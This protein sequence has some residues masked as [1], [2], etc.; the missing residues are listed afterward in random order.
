MTRAVQKGNR[1]SPHPPFGEPNLL[2]PA[3]VMFV[4][5]ASLILA[6]DYLA[7]ETASEASTGP[8]AWILL[9]SCTASTVAALYMYCRRTRLIQEKAQIGRQ[10]S[11]AFLNAIPD[12]IILVDR[13]N[14]CTDFRAAP[15]APPVFTNET[16]LGR[17]ISDFL[18]PQSALEL[19]ETIAA[20]RNTEENHTIELDIHARKGRTRQVEA[21]IV[22]YN[23]NEVLLIIREI[24][25]SHFMR[26]ILREL[27]EDIST[28]TG[29]DFFTSMVRFLARTLHADYVLVG[30]MSDAAPYDVN[31]LAGTHGDKL[32][33]KQFNFHLEKL[34]TSRTL[35]GRR[36]LIVPQG[37]REHFS[38]DA[39]LNDEETGTI[40]NVPLLDSLGRRCG[41]LMV[42]NGDIS[43]YG[44]FSESI[45]QICAD[46]AAGELEYETTMRALSD[47]VN[48]AEQLNQMKSNMLAN[49]NH[50]F[51]TPMNGILG[52][53]KI[54]HR[55]IEDPE[56]RQYAHFIFQ[57]AERLM[58]TLRDVIALAKL[59]SNEI[60]IQWMPVSLAGEVED[61]VFSYRS[62]IE[63]RGL[64]LRLD[65]PEEL[66]SCRLDASLLG[67]VLKN[68]L[69]NAL[70]FTQQ[71][72]IRIQCRAEE[73]DG[74]NCGVIRVTDT[75]IGMSPEF[76]LR[77]FAAFTQE[78]AGIDRQFEGSGIGLTIVQRFVS[79]MNGKVFVESRKGLGS[80]FTVA[81]PLLD[82]EAAQKEIDAISPD[83]EPELT[84]GNGAVPPKLN[85]LVAEDD[86]SNQRLIGM[87][88]RDLANIDQ[89]LT[90]EQ[91]LAQ[92]SD[93]KYDLI[94]FDV[95]LGHGIR[96]G[97]EAYR[98]IRTRTENDAK[99][100]IVA[101]TAYTLKYTRD[102]FLEEGFNDYISKPFNDV[103][104]QALVIKYA[105]EL[106]TA[107]PRNQK[108]NSV[109]QR[110]NHCSPDG[111]QGRTD[112][113]HEGA[114]N[115]HA[116]E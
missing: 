51:R 71:G 101:M 24:S 43:S 57:S 78:S 84:G 65:L 35:V 94:L 83:L 38:D 60:S 1:S 19:I 56:Q 107:Q 54:L 31:V 96:D 115:Q 42:I 108:D 67:Q 14:I 76:Q 86:E 32:I 88:L 58:N 53:A 16:I 41:I 27:A 36:N 81:F 85:I 4:L 73:I 110:N 15:N 21:R 5:G 62:Q 46:R 29:D 30:M 93:K 69:D 12:L 95:N 97:I 6:W 63:E 3:A 92:C 20:T 77:A 45:V 9:V 47:A 87:Y 34:P 80:T 48:Q 104:I 33:S 26:R 102:T 23:K 106:Q 70:K 91:A 59:E 17:S 13:H 105:R 8:L 82:S 109:E 11:Q 10:R 112:D 66:V 49:L 7:P 111:N 68:L 74:E 89:A 98:K 40:V 18:P 113:V 90:A 103:D 72:G 99:V 44:Q 79:I 64:T 50:E 22:P 114:G 55:H 37:L 2:I 39:S 116:P 75:G 28:K 61:V 25:D 52:F 100:P